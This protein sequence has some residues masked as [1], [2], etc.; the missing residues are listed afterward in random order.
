MRFGKSF[1]EPVGERLHQDGGIVVVGAREAL[2]DRLLL[3]AGGDDEAADIVLLAAVSGATK[4]A[5]ARFGLAVALGELL[6]QREE[7]GE[8]AFRALVGEQPDVVADRVGRPEADHRLRRE[9]ALLDDL[10]QHRLRVVEE[11]ARGGPLLLVIEDCRIA[12]LQLPG[13]EERRPVDVAGE[14]RQ[15][16]SFRRRACRGSSA[17]AAR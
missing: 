11:L 3:D 9:P 6:A 15:G 1:G 7:G 14:L 16:R 12:A 17:S 5:S 13:L 8:V 2:G 4:S 10:A